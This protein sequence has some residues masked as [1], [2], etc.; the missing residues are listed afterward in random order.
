MIGIAR[1]HRLALE[2]NTG[3]ALFANGVP[4]GY[5]GVTPLFRQANTGINIFDPFR[6]GE[7]AFLWVQTLRA[8]R[9]L[10]GSERFVINAYQFGAGNAEAIR[11]G[12]FWFYYRL[13]FRPATAAVRT[14]AAREAKR[15]TADAQVSKRCAYVTRARLRRSSSRSAGLRSRGSFR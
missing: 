12:A 1:E 13:G 9:T 10:Y 7:A 2:T 14:L 4:I 15:M 6:G 3:Y 8:F 11:S 5:G